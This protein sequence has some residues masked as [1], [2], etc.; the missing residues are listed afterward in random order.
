M[1][2][3]AKQ[4]GG[5]VKEKKQNIYA[6]RSQ[7]KRR[8]IL[9]RSIIFLLLVMAV[10]V[11]YRRRDSWMPGLDASGRQSQQQEG[12]FPL[13]IPGSSEYQMGAADG[14]LVVL[15]DSYLNFYQTG[16]GQVAARQHTYGSAMLQTA[17][18]YALVYENG[19][20]RF[21]LDTPGKAVFE[22]TVSDP[23]IFGRVSDQGKVALVTGSETCACRMLVFNA[24]GQQLYARNCVEDLSDICFRSDGGGCYAVSVFMQEGSLKSVVNSYSFTSKDDLWHSQAL[25]M[26]AVSVYNTS[27][28]NA[29]VFGD[30]R[31]VFLDRD[32]A[33]TGS[34]EY[35]KSL[36]GCAFRDQTAVL[37]LSDQE[38]RS[39]SVVIL[40]GS[41]QSPVVRSYEKEIKAVGLLSDGTILV[42]LR[43][44]LERLSETGRVLEEKEISD[45]Y[46]GFRSVGS[47]IFLHGYQ[48]I[49]RTELHK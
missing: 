15:T 45:S 3:K 35:P 36:S 27:E 24:K 8:R 34:Y 43:S 33:V 20:T 28:G 22:K 49:D 21:R 47:Y 4:Q 9:R 40:D 5:A 38:R 42:Q 31:C 6:A 30:T 37:L 19:G 32:G 11:L 16:G 14:K 48:H 18:N 46:E 17:G 39:S 23:I 44:K 2:K 12:K 13:Y 26:L 29:F 41:T 25:D 7:K 10:M 1:A